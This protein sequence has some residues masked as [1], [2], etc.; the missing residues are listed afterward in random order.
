MMV[1]LRSS[2]SIFRFLSC[3]NKLGECK[4][5]IGEYLRCL[6]R[7]KGTNDQECRMMAK[8]YLRCR[9][10]QYVVYLSIMLWSRLVWRSVVKHDDDQRFDFLAISWLRMKWRTSD[11]QKMTNLRPYQITREER[12]QTESET[13]GR[14][15]CDSNRYWSLALS[16]LSV[17]PF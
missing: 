4:P 6:R 1:S 14:R 8:E 12:Q 5:I 16:R 2:L 10:E 11:L 17:Q 15:Y 3:Q 13:T 9:M 7:V